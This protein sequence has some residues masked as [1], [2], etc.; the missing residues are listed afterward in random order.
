VQREAVVQHAATL[1]ASLAARSDRWNDFRSALHGDPTDDP[2]SL[3]LAAIALGWSQ[4]WR[5]S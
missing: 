5:S 4:K 3:V 2:K 1:A